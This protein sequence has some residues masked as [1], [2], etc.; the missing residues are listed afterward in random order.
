MY[1][2]CTSTF[3]GSYQSFTEQSCE[4]NGQSTT[5]LTEIKY[6]F[7]DLFP[8]IFLTIFYSIKQIFQGIKTINNKNTMEMNTNGM[9]ILD[10]DKIMEI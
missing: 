9:L 6:Y 5:F 3:I 4:N 10:S 2:K 8:K 1:L 7:K